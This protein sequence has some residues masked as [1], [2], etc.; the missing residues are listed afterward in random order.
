MMA[1]GSGTH[2]SSQASPASLISLSHY[3]RS[4]E[5]KVDDKKD[6][7]DLGE[8][9]ALWHFRGIRDGILYMI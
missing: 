9:L 1:P 8:Y 7:K 2:L 4:R 5:R 3:C 6:E